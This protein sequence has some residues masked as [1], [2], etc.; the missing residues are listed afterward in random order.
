MQ[1]IKDPKNKDINKN[2]DAASEQLKANLKKENVK[3]EADTTQ[4]DA[5]ARQYFNAQNE[6]KD[7]NTDDD[8]EVPL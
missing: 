3:E 6:D 4:V 2:N 1:L 5:D 8:N 7:L